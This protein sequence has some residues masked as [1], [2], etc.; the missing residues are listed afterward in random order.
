MTRDI[1][2]G[3]LTYDLQEFTAD[4][5]SRVAKIAPFQLKAYPIFARAAA[6]H[7]AFAYRPS[8]L[9][10]HFFVVRKEGS[11]P[12]GLT[13]SINWGAAWSCV[14]ESDVVVL[15]GIQGGT[16]LIAALLA[17]ARRRVL[18]SVN[19]TLPPEWEFKRRWWVRWLKSLI[20]HCCRVHVVQTPT[21]WETLKQVYGIPVEHCVEAPFE[22]GALVFQELLSKVPGSREELRRKLGWP[23]SECVFLFVGTLLRFKGVETIIEAASLLKRSH[24]GFRVVCFGPAAAQPGEPSISEYQRLAELK[25]VAEVVSFM[26]PHLL[27][28]L[29]RAYLAADALLLPTQRDMWPKVLVEAALAGLPLVTT[30]ACGAAGALVRDEETGLVIPP[31]DPAALANA[32]IN[33]LNRD[34][35][36]FLGKKA[37]E[38]CLEFCDQVKEGEGFRR[39]IELAINSEKQ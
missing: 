15:F 37:R 28:V 13:Y 6:D 24:A 26:G 9:A 5:L 19:Q 7:I 3:F 32:M 35:R 17:I 27:P 22:S 2:V 21:T 4:C 11:T 14:R 20:L 29:A 34:K 38:H 23:P 18:V 30:T 31:D 10:G 8:G 36:I 12:E 25:G 1:K 39:A 16:A 33:L